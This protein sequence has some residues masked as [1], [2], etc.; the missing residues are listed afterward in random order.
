[1]DADRYEPPDPLRRLGWRITRSVTP[2]RACWEFR[3]PALR[4]AAIGLGGA[5]LVSIVLRTGTLPQEW[6][7]WCVLGAC[8]CYATI[9]P[10][11]RLQITRD[12]WEL[13][14][15]LHLLGGPLAVFRSRTGSNTAALESRLRT[16]RGLSRIELRLRSEHGVT[17]VASFASWFTLSLR[18]LTESAVRSLVEQIH[19]DARRI[20]GPAA[21]RLSR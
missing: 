5:M 1:M 8:V 13:E 14:R 20:G 7:A 11:S 19:A 21:S 12:R 9:I 3:S 2:Q 4:R 10:R 17:V 18:D 16:G 15:R 6:L